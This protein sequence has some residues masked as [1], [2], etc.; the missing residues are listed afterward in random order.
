MIDLLWGL[1]RA[2]GYALTLQASGAALFAVGLAQRLG[3]SAPVIR[4]T[5]MRVAAGALG[6][7]AVQALLEPAHL[8]GEWPGIADP[9]LQR[10]VLHSSLGAAFAMRAVGLALLTVVLRGQGR[11]A[12]LGSLAGVLIVLGSFA[13]TGHT[14]LNAHRAALAALLLVHVG[15]VAFWFG[16]LGPL[17]QLCAREP[18]AAAASALES[19]SLAA[20]WLVLLIPLAGA[21]MAALLLP[22]LPALLKPYGLLLAGKAMLL[23]VLLGLATLNKWRLVPALSRG[24]PQAARALRRSMAAEYALLYAVF[25]LTSV[26]TGFFSPDSATEP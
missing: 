23:A 25:A 19:F 18:A 21:G 6:V 17:R 14:V 10:L 16:S 12:R 7:L 1:A 5:T 22:D 15:I 4:R 11:A 2:V 8:A 26:L 20:V 13:L 3:P 9:S 24:E